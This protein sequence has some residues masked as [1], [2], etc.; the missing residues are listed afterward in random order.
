MHR[1]L[2]QA[3][4]TDRATQILVANMTTR[5]DRQ[6]IR[7][8]DECIK[9]LKYTFLWDTY[10]RLYLSCVNTAQSAALNAID[11]TVGVLTQ[12][13]S[14]TFTAD[15]GWNGNGTSSYLNLGV[16]PNALT[17]FTQ[18]NACVG[19]WS[20]SA[21]AAST[22]ALLGCADTANAN[23]TQI[24]PRFTANL[25]DAR[26]NST[27]L[28]TV[29]NSNSAGHF[30][31]NRTGAVGFDIVMNGAVLASPASVSVGL[32]THQMLWLANN[33][34][35]TASSFSTFVSPIFHIGAALTASQTAAQYQIFQRFL[36]R[37][38]NNV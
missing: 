18:N 2:L 12:V 28:G 30:A 4:P 25:I 22:Q 14:P 27:I 13:A 15:Q 34:V 19:A 8:L 1:A 5:P 29:A 33:N 38:G 3:T 10:D 17:K 7:D 9:A 35:G 21:N 23:D 37:R 20:L 16:A 11:P 36:Q 26:L 6:L 24:F 31:I 32:S